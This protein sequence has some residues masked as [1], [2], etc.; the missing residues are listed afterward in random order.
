MGAIAEVVNAWMSHFFWAFAN[1]AK[2]TNLNIAKGTNLGGGGQFST[3]AE[4]ADVLSYP[5]V[6]MN[7][8][9][10]T[11]IL[12]WAIILIGIGLIAWGII[13]EK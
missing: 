12:I 1:I 3:P 2:G 4:Y 5:F 8:F 7:I 9:L 6:E 13:E 11:R 10:G